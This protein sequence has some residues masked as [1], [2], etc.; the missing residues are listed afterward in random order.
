M[1]ARILQII[2]PVLAI[3]AGGWLFGRV[4]RPEIAS[5]NQ[6]NMDVFVPALILGALSRRDFDLW[7]SRGLILGAVGV[8]LGSGLL[9]W[10]LARWIKVDPRTFVPPMMFNNSGNLGL[11]LAVLAFG[12]ELL[13]AAV[14]LFA[15]SNLLHFTLGTSIVRGDA[16]FGSFLRSPMVL[17]TAG[18][19]LLS[20]TG[21]GLPGF[22]GVAVR[23]AGDV[24][25]PLMIFTLGVRMATTPLGVWRIG[26]A[27]GIARPVAGL[28]AAL[29]LGAALGLS[30]ARLGLLYLFASL[31]PAILNFMVA[32]RYRQE[33]DR[34]ASIV[35]I[36]HLASLVFVPLGLALALRV[37]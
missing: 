2:L 28:A 11:P 5:V 22:A 15:T 3:V 27:G 13:P 24:A 31:P 23:L 30:G 8:V 32:E 33:P 36:G 26:L 6:M 4:A 35:L 17:A 21:I 20:A 9:A 16:H 19:V 12:E 10:P 29:P 25:V 37:G 14:A 1:A 34:V 7:G 18:G